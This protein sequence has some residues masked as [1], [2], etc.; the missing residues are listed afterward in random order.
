M[1]PS[2]DKRS[3]YLGVPL[4]NT[5]QINHVHEVYPAFQVTTNS[6]TMGKLCR[7]EYNPA[8]KPERDKRITAEEFSSLHVGEHPIDITIRELG[9]WQSLG[10]KALA[11]FDKEN[12]LEVCSSSV[13]EEERASR[14]IR[15][16]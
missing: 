15:E 4:A 2:K 1:H 5:V 9:G 13:I 7:Q 6:N 14:N 8:S 3:E 11:L 10:R 16:C 12:T